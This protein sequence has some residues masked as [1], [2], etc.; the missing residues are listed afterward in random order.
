MEFAEYLFAMRED[1]REAFGEK[2]QE[3]IRPVMEGLCADLAI[4][5]RSLLKE[6]EILSTPLLARNDLV[7]VWTLGAAVV[8]LY[9]L[10]ARMFPGAGRG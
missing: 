2:Y 1:V 10:R 3:F 7:S 8:E 6:F 9:E 4:Q 5:G